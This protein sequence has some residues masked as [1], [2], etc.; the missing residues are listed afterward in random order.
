M[1]KVD[2]KWGET[3]ASLLQRSLQAESKRLRE[4]VLALSLVAPWVNRPGQV[5][6]HIGRP[7]QPVCEG[8]SRFN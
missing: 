1:L 6:K 2:P 7:P 5:A 4:R 3:P 8:I